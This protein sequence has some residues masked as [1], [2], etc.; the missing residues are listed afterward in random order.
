[1]TTTSKIIEMPKEAKP[2]DQ[3]QAF[4]LDDDVIA[5]H[6]SH[7]WNGKAAH[8]HNDWKVYD[9]GYWQKREVQ[10]VRISLRKSLREY[11]RYGLK[12]TQGRISSIEAMLADELYIPD[13]LLMQ[14]AETQKK[15]IN[16]RNGLYNLET[17]RLEDHNPDLFF[18]H[19]LDF[20]YDPDA[21]C[22]NFRTYM[23]KSLVLPNGETDHA[24][25]LMVQQAIAYSMTART[26]LKASFWLVGKPDSGKSTFIAFIRGLMGSLHAT[27]DLNQLAGNKFMLSLIVGK[28]VVTFTE[29]ES[30]S[31]L[32]DGLYKAMVGGTDEIFADVKNKPGITFRPEAKFWWAMNEAP[33]VSDRSGATFNRL[34]IIPF[35]RS[36][37]QNERIPN[38]DKL[39]ISESAGVFN[40]IM[41]AY[42][43]LCKAGKFEHV[44]Q[45][46]NFRER[47]Q[48]ENDTEAT[49]LNDCTTW[50]PTAKVQSQLLYNCYRNWCDT[51]GFKPKNINQ[52]GKEWER[53]GLE[54]RASD[55]R[56][57]WH[58]I[59]LR[60]NQPL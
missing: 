50:K 20:D 18:T 60:E 48:M 15:Y 40:D 10:E 16:L 45:S 56:Y 3:P 59:F 58:G 57:F 1:M 21:D 47:F 33:R 12:V 4:H 17:H 35:N 44:P 52:V 22:P 27:I 5:S 41:Y 39:L 53:L 46:V 25:I 55:G 14:Q 19:Q 49:F 26:D 6:I 43:R 28:R 7:D 9:A 29:A 37:P 11:Q 30:N 54:K 31:V 8:F 36:V 51:N 42:Q 34:N 2:E 32:P 23:N 24:L 38:L 13:R